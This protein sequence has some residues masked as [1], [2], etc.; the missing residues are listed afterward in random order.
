MLD[1]AIRV[2]GKLRGAICLEHTGERRDWTPDEITFAAE[3]AEEAREL[4]A[5]SSFDLL[6]FDVVLADGSGPALADDLVPN[7]EVL[8][9]I[10]RLV[11][12]RSGAGSS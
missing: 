5:R 7:G 2:D 11:G 9:A 4:F 6:I 3:A 10:R 8:D 1:A 12:G